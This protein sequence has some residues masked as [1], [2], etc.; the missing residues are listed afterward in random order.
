MALRDYCQPG[1]ALTNADTLKKLRAYLEPDFL[2]N[3]LEHYV[4]RDFL[5]DV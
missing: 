5:K 4:R 1:R 3:I 2:E